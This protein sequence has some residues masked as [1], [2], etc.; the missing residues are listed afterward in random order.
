MLRVVVPLATL[1]T[2]NSL[3][4][5]ST[6]AVLNMLTGS[7]LRAVSV[8]VGHNF[9]FVIIHEAIMLLYWG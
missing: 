3:I 7:R 4:W 6:A 8:I 9:R 5:M 2:A 1:L